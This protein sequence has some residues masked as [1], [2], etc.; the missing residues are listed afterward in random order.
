MP[1]WNCIGPN[2]GD[3]NCRATS[4]RQ[5]SA[6]LGSRGATSKSDSKSTCTGSLDPTTRTCL[7][8]STAYSPRP[9]R[10]G[11]T[12]SAS[13]GSWL[14]TIVKIIFALYQIKGFLWEYVGQTESQFCFRYTVQ[15]VLPINLF[16]EKIF[17][18]LWFWLF[19]LTF[20]NLSSFIH[21]CSKLLILPMQASSSPSSSSLPHRLR[22]FPVQM[23]VYCGDALQRVP[24]YIWQAIYG[25]G[26]GVKCRICNAIRRS[27]VKRGKASTDKAQRLMASLNQ[28]DVFFSSAGVLCQAAAESDGFPQTRDENSVQIHPVLPAPRRA[29]HSQAHRYATGESV[30]RSKT[31]HE[32]VKNS[33]VLQ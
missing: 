5:V 12:Q 7:P 29:A 28:S 18:F 11:T 19:F 24:G 9:S 32:A 8:I 1:E 20:M 31:V 10:H 17:L 6:S 26:V 13:S 33:S 4:G 22:A 14:P 2:A 3:E 21:W 30:H 16:N 25:A 15:C 27:F 23:S